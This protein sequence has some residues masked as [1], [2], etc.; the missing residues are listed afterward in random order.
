MTL[1]QVIDEWHD[2]AFYE[3]N[4]NIRLKD[5]KK[6]ASEMAASMHWDVSH[7]RWEDFP[8]SQKWFASGEALSHLEHLVHIGLVDRKDKNGMLVYGLK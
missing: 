8:H 7:K 6:T 5:G 1:I 4:Y 2:M 3:Y